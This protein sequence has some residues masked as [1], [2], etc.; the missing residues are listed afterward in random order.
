MCERP[1][2]Q[3]VVQTEGVV[4]VS[5]TIEKLVCSQT[6]L[7][8]EIALIRKEGTWGRIGPRRRSPRR[9]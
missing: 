6:G 4:R 9:R 8:D 7:R 2:L 1:R 3:L 5:W